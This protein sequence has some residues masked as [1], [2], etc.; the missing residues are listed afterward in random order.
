[1][2]TG[3]RHM[4]GFASRWSGPDAILLETHPVDLKQHEDVSG[5]GQVGC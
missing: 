3:D 2:H 5:E 1:M 4:D